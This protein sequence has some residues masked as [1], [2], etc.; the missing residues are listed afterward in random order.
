MNPTL[1]DSVPVVAPPPTGSPLDEP[2]F[3]ECHA[4][5]IRF[6]DARK[7]GLKIDPDGTHPYQFVAFYDGRIHGY[8]KDPAK[9][10][11]RTARELGVHPAWLVIDFPWMWS[12]GLSMSFAGEELCDDSAGATVP[13]RS[14]A[15]G[16]DTRTGDLVDESSV[17][18]TV[19]SPGA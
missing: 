16:D 17:P 1:T 10:R 14:Q 2:T 3:E 6:D 11:E 4:E 12:N 7:A 13:T 18:I 19:S 9:L 8:D 5:W 15:P